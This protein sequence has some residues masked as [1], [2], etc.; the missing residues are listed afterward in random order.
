MWEWLQSL[1]L[2]GTRIPQRRKLLMALAAV[3]QVVADDGVRGLRAWFPLTAPDGLLETHGAS[4][5]IERRPG[6][7]LRAYRLRLAS[8]S[9]WIERFGRRGAMR[10]E[11]ELIAPGATRIYEFPRD[12]FR[13]GRSR[14]G[15]KRWGGPHPRLYVWADTAGALSEEAVAAIEGYLRLSLG[16]DIEIHVSAETHGTT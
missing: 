3:W 1:D 8:A 12:S 10:E 7:T 4:L 16:P 9:L 13:W 2:R 5:R 11:L 15:Q 14:W 6:E